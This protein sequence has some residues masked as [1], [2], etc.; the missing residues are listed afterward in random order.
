MPNS[1]CA[2]CGA[3]IVSGQVCAGCSKLL[4]MD[5]LQALALEGIEWLWKHQEK[6][7][8]TAQ[9]PHPQGYDELYVTPFLRTAAEA[10]KPE[11]YGLTWDEITG[12]TAN[13]EI[14]ISQRW[15][16]WI[17]HFAK[18]KIPLS[19][20]S[21]PKHQSLGAFVAACDEFLA[22]KKSDWQKMRAMESWWGELT[23]AEFEQEIA[24]L[25]CRFGMK[26]KRVGKAGDGGIDIR[27]ER[28][29]TSAILVQCKALDKPV[30]PAVVREMIGVRQA[31][32]LSPAWIVSRSGFSSDAKDLARRHEIGLLTLRM[33]LETEKVLKET[34]QCFRFN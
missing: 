12:K 16:T 33:L 13:Y 8:R 29:G 14:S 25:L 5:E 22:R 17:R 27:I 1:S 7:P 21:H 34:G 32:A 3:V 9:G 28:E 18:K 10:P 31:A 20:P 23:G 2:R 26:A 15:P 11:L 19:S 30:G 24:A 6:F 4:P